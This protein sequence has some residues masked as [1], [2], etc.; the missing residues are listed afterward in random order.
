MEID[1]FFL[2]GTVPK[3]ANARSMLLSSREPNQCDHTTA[4]DEFSSPHDSPLSQAASPATLPDAGF[5]MIANSVGHV[6]LGSFFD[7]GCGLRLPLDV[8][9][10]PKA[11]YLLRDNEMT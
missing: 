1:F 3:Y 2:V 9:F 8:C 5:R 11:T 6:R 10:S 4:D 7:R